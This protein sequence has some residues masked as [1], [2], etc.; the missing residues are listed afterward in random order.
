[1]HYFYHPALPGA[2]Q[3]FFLSEEEGLHA[4]KVLRMAVGDSIQLLDGKGGRFEGKITGTPGKRCQVAWHEA[5]YCEKTWPYVLHLAVA[6]TKNIDRMEWLVEKA[7]E[8]GIDRISFLQ[9]RY[10][11]RK[12]IRLDRIEKVALAAVKQSGNLFMPELGEMRPFS[13]FLPT[14][15]EEGKYIAHIPAGATLPRQFAKEPLPQRLCVLIGPEGGFSEEEVQMAAQAG[16][17]PV[18]L[19]QHRL[20]TETAALYACQA[21]QLLLA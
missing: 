17:L 15:A 21:A 19:S 11:E 8:I 4:L 6:P 13:A 5:S 12:E 3:P 2:G 7:V 20:R 9:T 16:F 1:M 14:V 10:S 18:G